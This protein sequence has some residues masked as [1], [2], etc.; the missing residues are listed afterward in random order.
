MQINSH[1]SVTTEH[2][3]CEACGELDESLQCRHARIEEVA[4]ASLLVEQRWRRSKRPALLP[5][6]SVESQNANGTYDIFRLEDGA[7]GCTCLSFLF[8]RALEATALPSGITVATCKH[9]RVTITDPAIRNAI[10]ANGTRIKSPSAWQ[11]AF[12][13][14]LGVEPHPKLTAEQAYF[15][16]DRL[17]SKQGVS[18]LE[19]ERLIKHHGRFSILPIYPFGIEFEGFQIPTGVLSRELAQAGLPTEVQNYNHRTQ[20]IFKL[21]TDGS[22]QGVNPFELVTPKLFGAEGFAKLDALCGV[23]NRLGGRVNRSCGLHVHIDAWNFDLPAV[24]RLVKV[25]HK[26]EEPVLYYLVPV[27]RRD[28]HYCQPL[29]PEI[30]A[31]VARM[32]SLNSLNRIQERYFSFNLN[33]W[34][35]YRTFEFRK[36]AGTFNAQKVTAWVIFLL[37]LMSAVK[38]GLTDED[39]EPTWE[40]VCKAIGFSEGTSLIARAHRFLTSRYRYWRSQ[41]Q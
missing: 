25:I 14:T 30:V 27:S 33:A 16:I 13:K 28:N 38:N 22:I 1:V 12:A 8:N 35:R 20:P 39:V 2:V 23:I 36:H 15:A 24:K 3:R 10:S 9:I 29:T 5:V 19:L 21:V 17:L 6:G 4:A 7:L 31:D 37:M 18:Y 11:T 40:G 32:R 41:G 26:I 34:S